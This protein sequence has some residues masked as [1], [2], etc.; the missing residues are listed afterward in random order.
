MNKESFLSSFCKL[1][2]LNSNSIKGDD[3]LASIPSWDSLTMLGLIVYADQNFGI[4]LSPDDI[5]KA[6][7][8]NDLYALLSK[9]SI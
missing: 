6:K 7:T 1:L 9:K 4:I 5:H 2:E 3:L 8:V